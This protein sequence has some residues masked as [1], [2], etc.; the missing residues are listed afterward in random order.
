MNRKSSAA[1]ILEEDR[2]ESGGESPAGSEDKESGPGQAPEPTWE[3]EIEF[4]EFD[5]EKIDLNP[6]AGKKPPGGKPG[7]KLPSA[8]AVQAYFN[9][10][11]KI[12]VQSR[13]E[14]KKLGHDLQK[15]RDNLTWLARALMLEEMEFGEPLLA[16][17]EKMARLARKK[18]L[19]H[20]YRNAEMKV[21]ALENELVDHNLRLVV[22]IARR[23][24]VRSLELL[25]L[26]QEGNIGMKRAAKGYDPEMGFRFSTYA[27]WWIRQSINRAIA[28]TDRA[29]RIPVH[30][31]EWSSKYR[32]AVEALKKEKNFDPD[33]EPGTDEIAEFMGVTADKV[34]KVAKLPKTPVSL[35]RPV[36]DAGGAH[37][38]DLTPDEKTPATDHETVQ[39]GEKR[40][41]SR[42]LGTLNPREQYIMRQRCGIDY[43]SFREA[44]GKTL[45][46]IAL[47]L[48]VS[49]ERVRQ[50]ESRVLEKLE[51]AAQRLETAEEMEL[52]Q[53]TESGAQNG[54]SP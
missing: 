51:R 19:D 25:D 17:R 16:A 36:D 4:E 30:M 47:D 11:A 24:K 18:K 6:P 53:N 9:G 40:Y 43:K 49:R 21:N 45:A 33:Y 8:N 22:F 46:Q 14:E 13:G 54:N 35:D 10:I 15:A 34:R 1:E 29:I 7:K 23:Y 26:I 52:R 44:E 27:S 31:C 20:E 32:Q 2:E 41:V 38:V 5:L 3:P 48:E 42:L 12:P 28:D 37:F 39:K 50:I